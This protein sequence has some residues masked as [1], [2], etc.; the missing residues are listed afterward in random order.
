MLEQ[1]C[2]LCV[3]SDITLTRSSPLLAQDVHVQIDGRSAGVPSQPK[4]ANERLYN[5]ADLSRQRQEHKRKS[6]IAA[7]QRELNENRYR[8]LRSRLCE[9]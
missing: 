3:T 6:I 9:Q 8:S 5:S 7:E 2:P 4:T 1:Q